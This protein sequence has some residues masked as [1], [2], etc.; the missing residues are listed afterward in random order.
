[1]FS[2]FLPKIFL[3][4]N[5]VEVP[6]QIEWEKFRKITKEQFIWLNDRDIKLPIIAL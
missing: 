3:R 4:R 2:K 6:E 1:M 5:K